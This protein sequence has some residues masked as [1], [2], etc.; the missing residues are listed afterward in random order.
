MSPRPIRVVPNRDDG[1][2]A[3]EERAILG[4]HE[5]AAAGAEHG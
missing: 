4:Y 3:D 2:A 5:V 1:P